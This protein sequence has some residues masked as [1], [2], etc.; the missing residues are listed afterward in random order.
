M[1]FSNKHHKV[2]RL[3]RSFAAK[4]IPP[5]ITSSDEEWTVARLAEMLVV[6]PGLDTQPLAKQ[7]RQMLIPE[8]LVASIGFIMSNDP[9]LQGVKSTKNFFKAEPVSHLDVAL[10]YRML[11]QSPDFFPLETRDA[12]W[13]NLRAALHHFHT[14]FLVGILAP[15]FTEEERLEAG[16]KLAISRSSDERRLG[17]QLLFEYGTELYYEHGRYW[18][19]EMLRVAIIERA[20][21]EESPEIRARLLKLSGRFTWFR[22][23]CSSW[24]LCRTPYHP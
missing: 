22:D 2:F 19:R 20:D 16:M 18:G 10:V 6:P 21:R 13:G 23:F 11:V 3:L 17:L 8:E 9:T 14:G 5:E 1:A 24:G 4:Q 12:V 15:R 7:L